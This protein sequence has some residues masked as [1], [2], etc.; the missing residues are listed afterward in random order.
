VQDNALVLAAIWDAANRKISDLRMMTSD[1]KV[2]LKTV[3][4]ICALLGEWKRAAENAGI[5]V[6]GRRILSE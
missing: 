2:A 6:S 5:L 4:D 3:D 1:D